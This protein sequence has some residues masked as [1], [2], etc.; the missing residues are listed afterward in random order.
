VN[1]KANHKQEKGDFTI[2][3]KANCL[4]VPKLIL[5]RFSGAERLDLLH[6]HRL[7]RPCSP[8]ANQTRL[9][10]ENPSIREGA[11]LTLGQG[12]QQGF[13]LPIICRSQILL[14]EIDSGIN[15]GH[16]ST[17]N[18]DRKWRREIYRSNSTHSDLLIGKAARRNDVC[19]CHVFR[20][21]FF[22]EGKHLTKYFSRD[23]NR[24]ER[25]RYGRSLTATPVILLVLP[26]KD[27]PARSTNRADSCYRIPIKPPSQIGQAQPPIGRRLKSNH[28]RHPQERRSL[29]IQSPDS[30]P[31]SIARARG[32]QD[33][34]GE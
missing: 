19:N 9:T 28:F 1:I 13:S 4:H 12:F 15:R 14:S 27:R 26:S 31:K 33:G 21:T 22:N 16:A 20:A 10:L 34:G 5:A 30:A 6:A 23:S 32:E 3:L 18:V 24:M 11:S 7:H 2:K 17:Y 29:N 25:S 8:L